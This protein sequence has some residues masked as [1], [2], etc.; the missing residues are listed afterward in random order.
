MKGYWNGI[1]Y[2]G[3][4]PSIQKYMQFTSE[5]EYREWYEIWENEKSK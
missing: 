2:M 4:L 1:A 5:T 3:Y